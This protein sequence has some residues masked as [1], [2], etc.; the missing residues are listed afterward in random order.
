MR[1]KILRVATVLAASTLGVVAVA[2]PAAAHVTVNPGEVEGGD[3]ARLVFQVPTESEEAD[4]V[5]LKVHLPEDTPFASVRTAPV[6]G[7]SAEM[8]T[9]TLDEPLEMHGR[10]ID[11]A[12]SVIT[13]TADGDDDGVKPGEFGEFPVSV[14]PLPDEGELIFKA[15]QTYSDD[16]EVS[17]ID[18]PT[19][20]HHEPAEPAPVLTVTAADEAAHAAEEE[21]SAG[22]SGGALAVTLAG[23]A[24]ALALAALAISVIG[25]RRRDK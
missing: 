14:G 17:W 21:S 24:S 9:T 1:S 3:Y 18:E 2:T 13:W 8:E 7:W 23:V 25:L 6:P 16:T 20:G 19:D 11:E 10:E 22:N 12:V 15:I 4:T 5:A